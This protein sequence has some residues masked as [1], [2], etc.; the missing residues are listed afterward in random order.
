MVIR[1]RRYFIYTEE[2]K[3]S[4]E[5]EYNDAAIVMFAREGGEGS[6][7]YMEDPE[8]ISQLA[9]HQ[10]EKDLLQMINDSGKFEKIIV[11]LNTGN[12]MEVGWLDEYGV[13]ACLW[14]GLPGQRG[15]KELQNSDRRNQSFRTSCRNI[16][17]KFIISSGYGKWKL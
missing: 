15:L 10:S 14:I 9:L 5:E 17:G 6:E 16:C 11:L 3:A 8:G 1:R 12:A 13:D 4:W 2:L 7:L